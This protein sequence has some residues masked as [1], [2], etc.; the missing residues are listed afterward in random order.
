LKAESG[1]YLAKARL[2]LQHANVMLGVGLTEDADR[3][4]YLAGYQ[5]AQ[6]PIF[7]RNGA[8]T[9]THSGAHSEFARLARTEPSIDDDLRRFL[10]RTYD[11]KAVCDY[12]L[13]PEA[14]VP[15]ARAEAALRDA[16]RFI[17]CIAALVYRDN[18]DGS[19]E[20]E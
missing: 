17:D 7:E 11:L 16:A 15:Y 19:S 18:E 1:R 6:A 5:A 2:T 9:K 12:E 20:P 13:G 10:P 14:V 4:A 8:A 3:A